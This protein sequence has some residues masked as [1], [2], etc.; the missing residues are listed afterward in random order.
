MIK[1]RGSGMAQSRHPGINMH[2]FTVGSGFIG[3]L[4]AGG[5]AL[6]FVLGLPA[7]WYFVFFSAGCGIILAAALRIIHDRRSDRTR[8]LSILST[9][10]ESKPDRRT[11]PK[12]RMLRTASAH[13]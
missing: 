3:F 12:D 9:A 6:I 2:K 5:C 8:P 11:P 4:F 7:L 13:S 10:N 1:A